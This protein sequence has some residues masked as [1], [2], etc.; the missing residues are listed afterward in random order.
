MNFSISISIAQ[1]V[2]NHIRINAVG[3][4]GDNGC[5]LYV[6]VDVTSMIFKAEE[7]YTKVQLLA[8]AVGTRRL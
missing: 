2:Y 1:R 8:S 3:Q 5:K 7:I 4:V 6:L